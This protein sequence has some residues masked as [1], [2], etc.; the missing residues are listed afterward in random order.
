MFSFYYSDFILFIEIFHFIF[1]KEAMTSKTTAEKIYCA[2]CNKSSGLF[3]CRGCEKDF[4]MRH[5]N[6]HRQE[7]GKQLEELTV[8]HD[9]YRQKLTEHT[10]Q[11]PYYSNLKQ[12]I[13]QWEEDSIKKI[14]Q[15]ANDIH[16]DLENM[17][18]QRTIELNENLTKLA[19]EINHARQ[20]DE[21]FEKD[22]QEWHEKLNKLKHNL[23]KL[24][25]LNIQEEKN[26][27]SF[28]SKISIDT[29]T[30]EIFEK[31]CGNIEL[32][33]NNQVAVH[34]QLNSYA[35]VHGKGE[36]ICGE[37]R[38]RLKIEEYNSSKWIFLGI[39]SKNAVIAENL[40]N[41]SSTY[42]WAAPNQVY[43]NGV[44]CSNLFKYQNDV[45]KDDIVEVLL[46]CDQRKIS[47]KNERTQSLH[48]IDIDLTKCPL[49]WKLHII[50]YFA[51]DRIRFLST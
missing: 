17:I 48:E 33:N 18:Q 42:G 11:I 2:I 35:I 36:Y 16:K 6:E 7:L 4:C 1:K 46:N 19:V 23:T 3:T 13:I 15:L 30:S 49:P 41:S 40:L 14:H 32:E 12:K 43:I 27:T 29:T 50:M 22:I 47:L 45:Q 20:E 10:I 37:H 26:P 38:L 24:P 44:Y 51:G 34:D 25:L 21:Y 9:Q 39:I 8:E 31:I 5:A 28:I